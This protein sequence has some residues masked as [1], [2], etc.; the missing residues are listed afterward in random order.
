M[1]FMNITIVRH[2]ESEYNRDGIWAGR[3][4]CALTENGIKAAQEL[5]KTL[6]TNF[7]V[8]YCSPLKR[9]KQTLFAIVPD[10]E[11]V[12]D[13]RIIE[14]SIGDWENTSKNLYSDHDRELFRKG[15]LVPPGAETHKEVDKRVCDFLSDV[16]KK[17]KED[18]RVLV[19]THAGVIRSIKRSFLNITKNIQPSNFDTLVLTPEDYKN[20]LDRTEELE[21]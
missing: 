16:F 9:T 6:D 14:I 4:D 8:I 2:V 21:R 1:K 20:Y 12:Y 10:A 15:L 11:P 3:A 19:V 18:E 7:D 17:Y 5:G 13:D